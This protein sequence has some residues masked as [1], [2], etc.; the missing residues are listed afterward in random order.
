MVSTPI[1]GKQSLTRDS[2]K[3]TMCMCMWDDM[4]RVVKEVLEQKRL[5]PAMEEQLRRKCWN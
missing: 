4:K 2:K 1:G 3:E 5:V